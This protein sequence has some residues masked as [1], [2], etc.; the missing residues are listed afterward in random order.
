MQQPV[1]KI[2]DRNTGC[3]RNNRATTR[4]NYKKEQK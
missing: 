1:L 2:R 4:K 3:V